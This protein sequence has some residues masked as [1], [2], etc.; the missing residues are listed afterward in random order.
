MAF[1]TQEV[2]DAAAAST[3]RAV[4]LAELRFASRTMFLHNGVGRLDLYGQV[5]EGLGQWASVQG[6]AQ[7]R[8]AES[9]KV[10]LALSGVDADI[11]RIARNSR[12]D[13]EGR[14]A[15]LWIQLMDERWQPLGARIALLWGVMQR[16]VLRVTP[17][18]DGEGSTRVA[19]LEVE[20]AFAARSRPPSRRFT[21]A[22][23]QLDHPGD[24]FCRFVSS[25]REQTLV[26]PVF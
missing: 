1:V 22:D 16:L 10:T 20:N 14:Q 6:L 19:E 18:S 9:S 15:F 24:K 3:V 2:A 12:D 23:H 11:L 26:W 4:T 13:V 17:A 21:D 25:Q 7:V 8:T 5:W